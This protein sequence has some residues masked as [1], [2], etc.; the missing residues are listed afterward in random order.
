VEVKK[1]LGKG[2]KDDGK[3][4]LPSLIFGGF[5]YGISQLVDVG[6]MGA[7]KY[8]RDGWQT[9]PNWE[10]RYV[11]AMSRHF[12]ASFKECRDPES[13]IDH[14]AHLA[15]NCLALMELRKERDDDKGK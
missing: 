9:V 2:V 1:D 6:T 4:P 14:L 11:D 8:A 5:P 3:K 12:L 15:W 7:R 10:E 13:G